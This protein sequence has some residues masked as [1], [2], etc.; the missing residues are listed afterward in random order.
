M[1]NIDATPT[2]R[3]TVT[4]RTPAGDAAQSE[5][6]IATYRVLKTSDLDKFNLGTASGTADFLRAALVRIDDLVNAK[7]AVE[8]SDEVRDAVLNMQTAR[9]ALATVYFNEVGKA[10]EGN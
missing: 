1:F 4:V 7:G 3:R 5:T 10:A 6:M 9:T 2:F 8:Y